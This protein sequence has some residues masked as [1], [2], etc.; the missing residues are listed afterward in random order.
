MIESQSEKCLA[1]N[2]SNISVGVHVGSSL[3]KVKDTHLM[4]NNQPVAE[5]LCWRL[6]ESQY[7]LF[8][9][10]VQSSFVTVTPQQTKVRLEL[11]LAPISSP[12]WLGTRSTGCSAAPRTTNSRTP[13]DRSS[14]DGTLDSRHS[15]RSVDNSSTLL[16]DSLVCKLSRDYMVPWSPVRPPC[17]ITIMV[18]WWSLVFFT[19]VYLWFPV[20]W[21]TCV[22]CW[23]A[24]AVTSPWEFTQ[25]L[26][27]F[28]LFLPSTPRLQHRPNCIPI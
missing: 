7:A 20:G 24:H 3:T 22:L 9:E 8:S 4:N 23:W 16:D 19:A 25:I 28:M 18:Q 15:H 26:H 11:S 17:F 2:E 5:I 1:Q 14:S 21:G 12:I 6:S 10:A 27:P 13:T